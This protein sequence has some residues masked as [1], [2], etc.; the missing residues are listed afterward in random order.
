MCFTWN[1]TVVKRQRHLSNPGIQCSFSSIYQPSQPS[2]MLLHIPYWQKKETPGEGCN[3][4]RFP[5]CS[6]YLLVNLQTCQE[7]TDQQISFIIS[8]VYLRSYLQALLKALSSKSCRKS[9]FFLFFWCLSDAMLSWASKGL[10]R[11]E[12]SHQ[13]KKKLLTLM[14]LNDNHCPS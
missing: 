5:S 6:Y 10:L 11:E 3:S 7:I 12:K 8:L 14:I 4:G 1:T 13:T 2:K 9:G